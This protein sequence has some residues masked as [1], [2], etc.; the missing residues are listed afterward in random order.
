M[1][2]AGSCVDEGCSGHG[3]CV[4]SRCWCDNEYYGS[5]CSS[6][7]S[8]TTPIIVI[9]RWFIFTCYII[10]MIAAI[11]RLIQQTRGND[12]NVIVAMASPTSPMTPMT[13]PQRVMP[14]N[15]SSVAAAT[16]IATATAG[17]GVTANGNEGI[18]GG[19]AATA[20][21]SS[22]HIDIGRMK[23]H[24]HGH[25]L[26][27]AYANNATSPRG[28]NNVGLLQFS[29]PTTPPPQLSPQPQ[30]RSHAVVIIHQRH[31][32]GVHNG[33]AGQGSRDNIVFGC[34]SGRAS[35][36]ISLVLIAASAIGG[37]ICLATSRIQTQTMLH[38]ANDYIC[39]GSAIVGGNI[40]IYV[41]MTSNT[42]YIF[43][44]C[45]CMVTMNR[46]TMFASHIIC[47]CIDPFTS[48]TIINSNGYHCSSVHIIGDSHNNYD[49]SWF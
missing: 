12:V 6:Y 28:G 24:D 43:Y 33:R 10:T 7:L 14:A 18:E 15:A 35:V 19:T 23:S 4:S 2:A 32:S 44:P 30:I 1:G 8:S 17:G 27:D 3:E 46:N 39:Y 40:T 34:L 36:L 41:E 49:I 29:H 16:T 25:A 5:D 48:S 20:L 45:L 37:S 38:E 31:Q 11:Y 26:A 21:L 42:M 47:P 13:S 9:T 22:S